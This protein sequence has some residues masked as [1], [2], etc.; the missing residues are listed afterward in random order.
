[1]LACNL[2]PYCERH[3][4]VLC[5]LIVGG[6]VATCALGCWVQRWVDRR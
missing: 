2:I 6:L 1:M 4:N 5:G 3:F